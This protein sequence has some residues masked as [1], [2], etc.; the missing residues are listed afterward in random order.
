MRKAIL[1]AIAA[2]AVSIV[3]APQGFEGAHPAPVGRA[4]AA[5]CTFSATLREG[6]RSSAVRCLEQMLVERGYSVNGPDRY[7]GTSTTRAVKAFQKT[8]G[9]RV[10]GIVGPKTRQALGQAAPVPQ[11]GPPPATIPPVI[12]ET[13]VIGKSVQGRD[14][15]AHRMGTPGGRV[16]LAVGVVH[17]DEPKGAEITQLLRTLPTPAGIDLWIIDTINP[18]G[19]LA[20]TRQNANLVDLNRNFERKWGYIPLSP[21]SS[22]YSGEAPADQPETQA[23]Q[24]F[25]REIRPAITVWWHQDANRVSA[26]G[27]RPEIGQAYA[28]LVNLTTKSTPCK[29]GCTGTATQF[30]NHTISGGTAFL[31]ELPNS[32]VVDSAMIAVHANAFLTVIT[33]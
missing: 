3:P 20:K 9:L 32:R 17:G 31:V 4:A 28:K 30:T 33:M 2:V 23:T 26:G 1:A 15:V 27:A 16:V 24:A 25:I 8:M 22:Q 11:P 5:N 10:D 18:D 6:A 12:I 14:I 19:L 13:R 7:F 21:T 29:S